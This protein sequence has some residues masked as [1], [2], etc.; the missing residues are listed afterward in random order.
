[1]RCCQRLCALQEQ[2][3]V[4]SKDFLV[5]AFVLAARTQHTL[6]ADSDIGLILLVLQRDHRCFLLHCLLYHTL[7]MFILMFF[8]FTSL[9]CTVSVHDEYKCTVFRIKGPHIPLAKPVP[10]VLPHFKFGKCSPV[11]DGWVILRRSLRVL[12]PPEVGWVILLE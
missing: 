10:G 1:M 9:L 2:I 12:N 3:H 6:L 11:P 5:V 4:H 8:K 7:S